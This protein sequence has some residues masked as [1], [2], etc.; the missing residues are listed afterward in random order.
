MN[1]A[2]SNIWEAFAA[3]A[4]ADEAAP[5]LCFSDRNVSYGELAAFVSRCAAYLR[6]RGVGQGSVVALQLPKRLEA[7]ALL[8]ACLRLGAPYLFI[9]P[10]NPPERTVRIVER[11]RP[12]LMVTTLSGSSRSCPA[13]ELESDDKARAWLASLPD[14]APQRSTVTGADPAYIM[15]TSGSTGEPKG[16]VIPHQGVLTLAA[17]A[18][19]EAYAGPAERLAN[20]NPLHFDNSV[21]DVYGALLN[22]AALIP[23]ETAELATPVAWVKAIRSS[24]ATLLFAV[25]TFFLVL[26]QL[27]LLTPESLPCVRTFMFGGEG[28]PIGRLREF[29]ARFMGRARLVNVYGPTE[30]SCICS[31]IE[32]D[33]DALAAPDGDFPPLGRMHE[34]FSHAILDDAH[35]PVPSG[36]PGELW[37]G[38]PCVGLGYYGNPQETA[39]RFRQDP[40]QDRYRAIYYRSGDIV[41]EDRRGLLWFHGR[42]DNQVKIRGYRIELE[43][44]DLAVQSV[45][46]VS[47]ALSVVTSGEA[48]DEIEVAFVANREVPTSEIHQRCGDR[49]PAYMRPARAVQLAALPS[50][51][52][53]KADR[54]ATKRLLEQAR[55]LAPRA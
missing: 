30:T 26:D 21:F 46:G 29:H 16:A 28:Y 54:R 47:R 11:V 39:A 23:V 33:A 20:V 13:L 4:R 55:E 6:T 44:V 10:K 34:N 52:N 40:R 2:G 32:I 45:P 18:R 1:A 41:R 49:L 48:G 8:L 7:Y 25:P 22:G 35:Q 17:W 14:S 19:R 9:D 12:A 3:T 5:A 51:A 53:G 31:S 15:F 24:A 37:I 42:A 38:G 27:G 50:N 43:E 36:E